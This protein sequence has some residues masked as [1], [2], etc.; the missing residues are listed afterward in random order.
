MIGIAIPLSDVPVEVIEQHELTRLVHDRGGEKELRFMREH[1]VLPVW[2]D[3]QLTIES[4]GSRSGKLPRTGYTWRA[5]IDAGEWAVYAAEEVVIPATAA[6]DRGV[7]YRVRQGVRGLLAEYAGA[8]AVYVVVEPASYYY[9]IM[10]RSERM[11]V[12]IG[13]RI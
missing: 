5:S 12:L 3:G 6:F 9:K 8:R 7:W 2:H 11:P 13:E 1:A 10:T 4:W